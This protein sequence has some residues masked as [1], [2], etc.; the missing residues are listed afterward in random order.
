MGPYVEFAGETDTGRGPSWALWNPAGSLVADVKGGNF[1]RGF[2]AWDDDFA[3]LST[4]KYVAT[5]AGSAGTFALVD[6]DNGVARA[7]CG[8][9]TSTHGINVQLGGAV[10]VT[11]TAGRIVYFE[12]YIKPAAIGTGPDFFLGL[13]AT[14]T[15]LIAS[16]AL[17]SACIGFSSITADSIL[18]S[19]CKDGSGTT[20]GTGVTLVAGT[21]VKLGMKITGTSKVEFFVN[22]T[23]VATITANI[24]TSGLR[25]TLVCQGRGTTQPTIDIDWGKCFVQLSA[26]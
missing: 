13:A 3:F 1:N 7:D 17:T 20:T 22:G 11:P 25:P 16:S 14:D 6:G 4:G 9:T 10:T 19:T 23:I 15:T 8:D 21:W 12:A 5:Q 2:E 24:S 18:L 26:N